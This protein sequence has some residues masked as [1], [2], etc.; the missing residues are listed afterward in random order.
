VTITGEPLAMALAWR[1]RRT[2]TT[3]STTPQFLQGSLYAGLWYSYPAT[4]YA[5]PYP[6][7]PP[8]AVASAPLDVGPAIQYW[9]FCEASGAYYPNVTTCPGGWK[10]VQVPLNDASP[11]PQQ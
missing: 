2:A 11:V 3:D 1:W 9:S 4:V 7:E 6:D 5:Y 10:Q 8:V